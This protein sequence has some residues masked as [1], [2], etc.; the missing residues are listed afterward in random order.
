MFRIAEKGTSYDGERSSVPEG[1][2][3]GTAVLLIVFFFTFLANANRDEW[4]VV[5]VGMPL[6]M[7]QLRHRADEHLRPSFFGH[8][9]KVGREFD[10]LFAVR[11]I[12]L[13]I[14]EV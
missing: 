3:E 2:F 13:V 4:Q 12:R 5:Y 1:F 11:C 14:V 10:A 6:K 8:S 9:R 7:M